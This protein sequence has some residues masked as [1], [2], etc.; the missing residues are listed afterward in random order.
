LEFRDRAGHGVNLFV[1]D[2]GG[3]LHVGVQLL[4]ATRA[5][6]GVLRYGQPARFVEADGTGHARFSADPV[7][8]SIVIHDGD[9]PRLQTSWVRL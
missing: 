3:R 9:G 6:L 7:L 8:L 4:P 1:E 2:T 5:T